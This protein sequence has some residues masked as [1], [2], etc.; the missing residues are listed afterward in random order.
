MFN[1]AGGTHPKV[2][3]NF[4]LLTQESDFLHVFSRNLPKF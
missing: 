3:F 4:S 2:M 1:N